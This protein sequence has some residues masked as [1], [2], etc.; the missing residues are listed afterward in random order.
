MISGNT[1]L[2]HDICQKI[3]TSS[4]RAISFHAF[5]NMCLYHENVGYYSSERVK[6]G[7]S[8]DFYTSAALGGL[9]AETVA[10]YYLQLVRT[11]WSSEPILYFVEWGGGDGAFAKQFLDV[12]SLSAPDIYERVQYQMIEH[13]AFHRKLQRENVSS[14]AKRV[15]WLDQ[16]LWMQSGPFRSI[17]IF[18]NELL[19]AFAV[20]RVRRE[21]NGWSELMVNY[22]SETEQF[23]E[24]QRTIIEGSELH[25]FL[26]RYGQ[27]LQINQWIEVNLDAYK[28]LA[29]MSENM[30]SGDIITIDY[31]DLSE[32]LCAPY[33]MNG[34]FLCYR[35]H[36]A[37]ENPYQWI[38]EQ[39]MTSHVNFSAL[40]DW[41][42]Q[43]GLRTKS[44][45]TQRDF[46]ISQGIL[47]KLQNT[48]E[49]RD[50]FHPAVKRNRHIRQL[51]FSDQMS[52][53]FKVLV[54]SKNR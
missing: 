22:S 12:I 2:I 36:K 19:D 15:Q 48:M 38:G 9:L 47:D 1:A 53:L 17:V 5:M 45:Q 51:L 40:M 16:Q 43:I 11:H 50:P 14:H 46:L 28:W 10:E 35:E 37:H 30:Q 24:T 33:R 8:G 13:S 18:S 4:E 49:I 34:T 7:K 31:G 32:E 54:Q 41:G 52:E 6:I 25:T 26:E 20:H 27:S 29:Q 42:E 23:G 44:Y 39:D 3:E 21:K